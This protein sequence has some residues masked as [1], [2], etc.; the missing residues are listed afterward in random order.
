MLYLSCKIIAGFNQERARYR[1]IMRK[2]TKTIAIA[3]MAVMMLGTTAFAGSTFS[4]YST[5]VGKFN[6][7]G[8]SSYQTKEI[9]GANG[10]ISSTSVGG[11]YEVDVRMNSSVG[12]G[13]WTRDLKSG[14]EAALPG[15]Y[16]QVSGTKVRAQ[17][18]NNITTPVDVQVTG[19]WASN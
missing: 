14:T 3:S 6:G 5:T 16:K 1:L 11:G 13:S 15:Y 4:S 9:D 19:S 2:I 8:Y 12:S 7:N 17:F 10:A 18:S